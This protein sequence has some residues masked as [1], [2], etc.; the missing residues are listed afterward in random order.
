MPT[1]RPR[2]GCPC[3]PGACAALRAPSRSSVDERADV[4]LAR[5]DRFGAQFDDRAR[6]RARRL[7]SGGQDRA[8]TAS[9][10]AVD[11]GRSARGQAAR[12]RHHQKRGQRRDRPGDD[13]GLTHCSRKSDRRPRLSQVTISVTISTIIADIVAARTNRPCLHEISVRRW[14]AFPQVFR[15]RFLARNAR[16]GS[17][18]HI[19]WFTINPRSALK[20]R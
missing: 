7:R 12:H 18:P 20:Q 5:R 13:I 9:G 16:G 2:S 10:G 3:R 17:R 4:A 11:Q 14:P 6:R 8:L 19:R 1:G 15:R